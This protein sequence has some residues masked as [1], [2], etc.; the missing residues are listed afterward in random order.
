MSFVVRTSITVDHPAI[1]NNVRELLRELGLPQSA[2]FASRDQAAEAQ[3]ML[4]ERTG[5]EWRVETA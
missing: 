4:E 2:R 5:F 1:Q 3:S